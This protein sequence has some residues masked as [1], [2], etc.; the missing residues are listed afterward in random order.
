MEETVLEASTGATFA[1]AKMA[2]NL[3]DNKNDITLFHSLK[4][5]VFFWYNLAA[6]PYIS[7]D[8]ITIIYNACKMDI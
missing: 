7:I 3:L 8:T 4:K 1:I 5:K 6:T 2:Y